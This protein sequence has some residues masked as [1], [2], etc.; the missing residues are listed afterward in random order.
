MYSFMFEAG[1]MLSV[2]TIFSTLTP[3]AFNRKIFPI[4]QNLQTQ[5]EITT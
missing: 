5:D 4:F 1:R 2:N 3:I